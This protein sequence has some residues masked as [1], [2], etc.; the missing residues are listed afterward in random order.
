[1]TEKDE[2]RMSQQELVRLHVI[3]QAIEGRIKQVEAA[4]KLDLSDRQ[5]RRIIKRVNEIGDKGI[6]HG[7][8]GWPSHRRIDEKIKNKA[9]MIYE[10][11]YWDFGPTLAS[12]KIEERDGIKLSD[13]TLRLWLI[14][15]GLWQKRKSRR[16]RHWRERK[17][18]LGEMEQLDGSHHDWFEG[19]GPKCVLMDYIDDATN[20]RFARFYEYEGVVPA[21]DSLKRYMNKYGIPVSLYLDQHSTYKSTGKQTIEDELNNRYPMS[22]L[23]RAAEELGIR[24]I[25]ATSAQAKGRV[26]RDFRTLQDRLVK[27]MRLEGI[28]DIKAAN[29]FLPGFLKK[30]NKMFREEAANDADMHR[31]IPEGMDLDLILCIKT[32]RLLRNDFTI[33]Y[34]KELYQILDKAYSKKVILEE[35]L[36]GQLSI[37]SNGKKLKYKKIKTRPIKEPEIKV[38]KRWNGYK[39][40]MSHPL[41]RQMFQARIA[42]EEAKKQ[43][44]ANTLKKGEL[45]LINN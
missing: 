3:R 37:K 13:E 9:L 30:H 26:E 29:K 44:F 38:R 15:K 40:P 20:R 27:E 23:E 45:V 5:I 33:A 43:E 19:R 16:H 31:Q 22:Q 39:P 36:K 10:K 11:S 2:I 7:L 18:C 12:E 17:S 24:I 32:E 1:M 42:R 35:D 8:R 25:H 4:E 6:I 41:K 28:S 34:E 14:Q 21:M